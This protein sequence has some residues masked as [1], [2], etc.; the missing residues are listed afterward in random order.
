MTS[1][2]G[3]QPTSPP[4]LLVVS[5]MQGPAI[6]ISLVHFNS[7]ILICAA[8]AH[9]GT[10]KRRLALLAQFGDCQVLSTIMVHCREKEPKGS[11]RT[12]LRSSF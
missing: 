11:S 4:G 3:G 8:R 6:C 12:P 5:Q 1:E 9:Y 2:V 10:M 7:L